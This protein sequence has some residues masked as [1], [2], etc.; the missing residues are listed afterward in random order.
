MLCCRAK[1]SCRS[2]DLPCGV[3]VLKGIAQISVIQDPALSVVPAASPGGQC[4]SDIPLLS[5]VNL[6]N[7]NTLFSVISAF[8]VVVEMGIP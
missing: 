5:Q 3:V 1:I 2:Q 4:M 8:V 7:S 6:M